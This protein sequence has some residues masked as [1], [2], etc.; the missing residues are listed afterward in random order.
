MGLLKKE[1]HIITIKLSIMQSLSSFPAM[2]SKLRCEENAEQ[3]KMLGTW[4]NREGKQCQHSGNWEENTCLYPQAH[5]SSGSSPYSHLLERDAAQTP[6]VYRGMPPY[7]TSSTDCRGV[8]E[9]SCSKGIRTHTLYGQPTSS[10]KFFSF[11][12]CIFNTI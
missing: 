12:M 5:M 11:Y 1:T 8:W 2:S 6:L 4:G 10:E 9:L 7:A 3:R